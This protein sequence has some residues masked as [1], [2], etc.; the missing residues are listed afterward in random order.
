MAELQ[1]GMGRGLAAILPSAAGG[2]G[3]RLRELPLSAIVPNPNQP[4]R[5]FDQ[6]ALSALAESLSEK[7]LLQPILVRLRP[8]GAYEL[9]AG[10]RRWRAARI[11]GLETIP[12]L[13]RDE[14]DADA[15]S[16]ELA[17]VE[18]M[19][20]E[21]LNP[22]EEA[23]ACAALVDR[24]GLTHELIGQRVGRS[25]VAIS[26]LI[27]LLDLPDD[28]LFLVESGRLSAGHGRAL[29][30]ASDHELRR[31]LAREA[32]EH[33]WS[34]RELE[35]RARGGGA[36]ARAGPRAARRERPATPAD[37]LAAL[38]RVADAFGAAIG[39]EVAVRPTGAGCTVELAFDSPENALALAARLTGVKAARSTP[40]RDVADA[41]IAASTGD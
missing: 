12:A 11:A 5:I 15:E 28:A 41:T 29:L 24:T 30:L 31:R 10:E 16:L 13:V 39:F 2:A 35:A 17:L 1:R 8:D 9:I 25:R 27:R 38:A 14:P 37:Q 20:R 7:G 21:D 34:V 4:R 19:A 26:N 33:G 18:N 40:E 6:I 32:V 3:D 36:R 23:R 22:I